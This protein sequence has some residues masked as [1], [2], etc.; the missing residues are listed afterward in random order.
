VEVPAGA[1][2]VAQPSIGLS[3]RGQDQAEAAEWSLILKVLHP[4]EDRGQSSDWGYWRREADAFQSGLVD[5]LP[6]GQSAPRCFGVIEHGD[7]TCWIWMEDL[8]DDIGPKWP[9]EHYGVAARH[10]G[11]FRRSLPGGT[12]PSLSSLAELPVAAVEPG[13]SRFRNGTASPGGGAAIGA[14]RLATG[15]R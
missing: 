10:L 8:Q 9:L 12:A 4:P 1:V 5:D 2:V 7:E 13:S 11:Q 14:P 6:G 3:G 15:P